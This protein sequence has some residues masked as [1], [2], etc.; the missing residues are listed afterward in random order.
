MKISS[1]DIRFTGRQLVA[2]VLK[3]TDKFIPFEEVESIDFNEILNDKCFNQ[4]ITAYISGCIESYHNQL[5]N[6]LLENGID[7]GEIDV[8]EQTYMNEYSLYSM[9]HD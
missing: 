8:D 1:K 2:T 5:R 6:K 3:K 4:A 9:T 7:I